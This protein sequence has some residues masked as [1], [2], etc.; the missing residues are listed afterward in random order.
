MAQW[1]SKGFRRVRSHVDGAEHAA[2]I[3]ITRL[4]FEPGDVRIGAVKVV[5][6]DEEHPGLA[7]SENVT[8]YK[9]VLSAVHRSVDVAIRDEEQ[10]RHFGSVDASVADPI[11]CAYRS[12]ERPW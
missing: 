4:V 3:A 9:V 5:M 11:A 2:R 7:G 6:L 12:S 1:P 8:V 10:A